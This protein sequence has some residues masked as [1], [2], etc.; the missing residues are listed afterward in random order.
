MSTVPTGGG[1]S[2]PLEMI[3][4]QIAYRFFDEVYSQQKPDVCAL[5]VSANALSHTPE[6][7]FHGPACVEQLVAV[8]ESAFPNASYTIQE[9]VADADVVTV[10]WNMAG[11]HEQPFHGVAATGAPVELEGAAMLRFDNH[12]NVEG[13]M[14]YDRIGLL[15]QIQSHVPLDDRICPPCREP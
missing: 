11:I 10:R 3:D 7:E 15:E 6:G 5:L 9:M 2:L 8:L 14:S 13:W 4:Q 12:L 1:A